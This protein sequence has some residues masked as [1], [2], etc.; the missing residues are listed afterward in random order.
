MRGQVKAFIGTAPPIHDGQHEMACVKCEAAWAA[1]DAEFKPDERWAMAWTD[2]NPDHYVVGHMISGTRSGVW[3][4]ALLIW[5][6]HVKAPDGTDL[7]YPHK[8]QRET[9]A[10]DRHDAVKRLR[11]RG[12]RVIRV[13]VV[14]A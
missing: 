11:R 6:L 12:V 13:K 8:K 10:I 5:F 9:K 14:S 1:S 3:D 7:Y 4:Q 2:P